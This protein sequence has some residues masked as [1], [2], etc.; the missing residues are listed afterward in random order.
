M[1]VPT[2]TALGAAFF[3]VWAAPTWA[4][5]GNQQKGGQGQP[6]GFMGKIHDDAP[7]QSLFSI[8]SLFLPIVKAG[9]ENFLR[10]PLAPF[11]DPS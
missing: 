1:A 7:F 3:G 4:E 9:I 8:V 11:F 6:Q 5:E 10:P 2:F